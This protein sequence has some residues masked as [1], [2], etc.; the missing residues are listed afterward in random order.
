MQI[1]C[2]KCQTSYDI[3]ADSLGP[4][5][6]KV[7]CIRCESVWFVEPPQ[8]LIAAPAPPAMSPPAM[9]GT[10]SGPPEAGG[11]QSEPAG[12]MNTD[13]AAIPEPDAGASRP[14]AKAGD[15]TAAGTPSPGDPDPGPQDLDEAA[16]A[17]SQTG[18]QIGGQDTVEIAD[19]PSII[20]P[21]EQDPPLTAAE[22]DAPGRRKRDIGTFIS[23]RAQKM[24]ERKHK[25]PFPAQA[26]LVVALVVT[27]AALVV[28]RKDVVRFAPQTASLYAFAGMPVNIRGLTFENVKTLRETQDGVSVLLVEGQIV[29]VAAQAAEVPRLRFSV[30][31]AKGQEVYSWTALAG[32]SILAPG[33]SMDFRSRLAAPPADAADVV[34]RFFNR[35]DT[36]ASNR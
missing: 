26:A 23:R 24:L 32:R 30:R 36:L 18:G 28:W 7:R 8:A 29:S 21:Q 4:E 17:A 34:V 2:P 31:N 19:A 12:Q 1:H 27:L 11:F 13:R 33:D 5:G 9:S 15:M 14:D 16:R 3:R 22:D 20:P 25:R 6:R 35:R 10:P